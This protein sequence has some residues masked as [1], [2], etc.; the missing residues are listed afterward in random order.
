MADCCGRLALAVALVVVVAGLGLA[1]L[2]AVLVVGLVGG[3]GEVV[4]HLQVAD[5]GAGDAGEG[6]L[7]VDGSAS[8]RGRAGLGLDLVAEQVDQGGAMAGGF[9]PV[10]RSRTISET[11]SAS[12]GL[13]IASI[14]LNARLA[15][16]CS[17]TAFRFSRTPPSALAPI[18]SMRACSMPS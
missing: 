14:W 13:A 7:V 9:S 10:S 8:G 4:A 18:A 11:T 2:A 15:Q 3:V 12:G 5:D 1:V 17:S 6:L 16:A